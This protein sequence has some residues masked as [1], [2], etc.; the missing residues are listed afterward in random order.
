MSGIAGVFMR[1]GAPADRRLVTAMAATTPHRAADGTWSIADGCFSGIRQLTIVTPEDCFETSPVVDPASKLVILFDGRLDNRDELLHVL[2]GVRDRRVGDARIALE[3]WK[4][5]GQDAPARLSGDFAF[6]VWDPRERTVSCVRDPMGV[7]PFFYYLSEDAFVFGSEVRQLLA[8]PLVPRAPDE[9]MI[10]DLLT[11][12]TRFPERTLYRDVLRLPHART[13]VVG[14]TRSTVNRYWRLELSRELKLSGEGEYAE[15]FRE[16]FDRAVAARL[17]SA[18]PIAAH[19]SGGLDSSSVFVTASAITATPI[20]AFSLVFPGHAE[21]DERAYS[22]AVLEHA[23]V[24]GV[25]IVPPRSAIHVARAQVDGRQYLSDYPNEGAMSAIGRAVAARGIRVALTGSGG[26]EGL[27][28]SFFFCADL[29]ASGHVR[30]FVRRYRDVLRYPGMHWYSAELLRTALWPALPAGLRRAVRPVARRAF[31][32]RPPAW[33]PPAFVRRT[34]LSN[35]PP[36]THLPPALAARYHVVQAY[37]SSWNH[38]ILDAAECGSA[39]LQI[40]R[41]HPFYDRQVVECM[42]A[43]P[44]DQ[45]WQHGTMKY[46]LRRAMTGRLPETVRRR[47]DASKSDFSHLFIEAL[48]ALGGEAFFSDGMHAAANGWVVSAR[49][50]DMYQR[51]RVLV[52]RRDIAYAELAWSLWTIAAVEMWFRGVFADP[53]SGSQA[54]MATSRSTTQPDTKANTRGPER[55][56]AGRC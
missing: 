4:A 10:A 23:G 20:T 19:L 53:R 43:L 48:D 9:M 18:G 50:R 40:E 16:S 55:A 14:A 5:W 15:A 29:L 32:P 2:S 30:R 24:T 35:P 22:G 36:P 45:R 52:E 12:G 26:D 49:V 41:R 3:A 21:C 13:L 7:R 44:D 46:V 6:A 33:V 39:E 54:W 8:H 25:Q 42:V 28:G 31:A 47:S 38:A 1:S 17:R 27:S 34:G 37:E 51:M 11:A 56:I